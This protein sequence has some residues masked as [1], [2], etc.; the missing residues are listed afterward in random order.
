M[1]R[2]NEPYI[3][4]MNYGYD[5]EKHALYFHCAK[6]LLKI[7]FITQNPA[8]C[9]TVLQ[10]L[11]YQDGTCNHLYQSLIIRGTLTLVDELEEKI[12]GIEVLLHHLEKDPDPIREKSLK[13]KN[14]YRTTGVLRLDIQDITGKQAVE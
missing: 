8:V 6:E 11:G 5:G 9:E 12:H 7:D 14:R 10:D 3:A 4:T 1:C 13:D 2:E